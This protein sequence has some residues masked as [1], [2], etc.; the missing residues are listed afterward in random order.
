ML[1]FARSARHA[2]V[3]AGYRGGADGRLRAGQAQHRGDPRLQRRRDGR[4][5]RVRPRARARGPLHRIHGRGRRH[6]VAMDEVVSRSARSSTSSRGAYGPVTPLR[7]D[8]AAPAERF[9][10]ADG[11]DVRDHRLDDA[12][13]LPH[14]RPRRASRPTGPCCSASTARAGSISGSRS[15][16]A[17]PTTEIAE[18]DRGHVAVAHRPRRRGARGARRPRRAATR[19]RASAPIPGA[20]C[21]R[22]A[23]DGPARRADRTADPAQYRQHRPALRGHRHSAPPDRAA[24]FSLDD[25][26]GEAR[27]ARLLGQDRP[28]GP[29]GL[30]RVPRRHQPRRCLYFSAN[31]EHDYREAPY[32][33]RSVLVFGSETEGMPTRILEKHPER[34]F[35]IPMPGDV[36]SLNL[37]NAVS[38]VLY[39]GLR[40]LGVE[41]ARPGLDG[42]ES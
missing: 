9:R 35:R 4:P 30:V 20:R 36:R 22:A 5:A 27:G 15:G 16:A 40:Q 2:D 14:L 39:E 12:A 21:T 41:R 3:L 6:A 7:E 32:R 33:D 34:C 42:P 38:V 13:V 8:A 24:G 37:A 11:T 29:P 26:R 10:L 23:A 31:A 28:L 17:R 25:T 1:A 19:S 18:P